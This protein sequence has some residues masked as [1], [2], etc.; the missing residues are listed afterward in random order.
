[1]GNKRDVVYKRVFLDRSDI[2]WFE[3]QFGGA[4]FTWLFDKMLKNLRALYEEREID[5]D[6]V[7]ET[8]NRETKAEIEVEEF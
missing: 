5:I 2:I 8:V 7:I 6:E 1:M 3:H 4:T